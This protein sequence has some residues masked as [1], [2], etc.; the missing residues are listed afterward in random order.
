MRIGQEEC[1]IRMS[2]RMDL[3]NVILMCFTFYEPSFISH[4]VYLVIKY[5]IIIGLLLQYFSW[6]KRIKPV[7]IVA[8]LYGGIT[9]VSSILNHMTLNTIIASLF[10]ALQIIDV[11]IV[12]KRVIHKYT[13]HTYLK[14]LFGIFLI[15]SLLTDALMLF[16]GYDFSDSAEKYLIGNKFVVAYVHCLTAALAF[17][18]AGSKGLIVGGTRLQLRGTSKRAGAYVYTIYSL[19][20]CTKITCATGVV[21]MATLFLLMLLPNRAKAWIATGKM[22]VLAAGV[23]N[24]LMFGSYSL[25]TNRVVL[26]FVQNVLG[27]SANFT[28]RIQIWTII[29]GQIFESPIIGQG[30]Y[31]DAI[32]VILGYG[33]PQNGV[34]KLLLD[35]GLLGLLFYGILV[36]KAFKR[37]ESENG[38]ALYPIIIFFYAMLV[39]SLVEIN[40]THMIVFLSMAIVASSTGCAQGI[41]TRGKKR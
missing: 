19:L 24:L 20:I 5:L 13:L 14:W 40:L 9:V 33:N 17:S 35:T 37:P 34:L 3:L 21:I 15:A 28:G 10:F 7:I 26:D 23:A 4:S 18:T 27:R 39:A 1:S 25:L 2:I 8:A 41:R 11:F 38:S 30:Y 6:A 31:S 12:T 29:F 36:W 22:M 32:N 16:I